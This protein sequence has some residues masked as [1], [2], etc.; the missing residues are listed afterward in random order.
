MIGNRLNDRYKIISRIGD[1]GMAVVYK[2]K[3]LILDRYCAVKILRQEFS[4]DEA[5]IR[6]FRR[7]AESVSSLSHAN[8]VN[9]YDIGE[10]DDLY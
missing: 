1:G 4:N 5:F 2:A 3:D 9:I 10:E 6:R 8:I 7:E